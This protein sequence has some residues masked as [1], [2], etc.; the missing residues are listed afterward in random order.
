M[1]VFLDFEDFSHFYLF[2]VKFL[3]QLLNL[4]N[5]G[6]LWIESVKIILK[7]ISF[8]H[9]TSNTS[10]WFSTD[11]AFFMV[12]MTTLEMDGLFSVI[13]RIPTSLTIPICSETIKFLIIIILKLFSQPLLHEI[14]RDVHDID[15]MG[16]I[17]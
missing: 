6:E 8:T 16:K 7:L 10:H 11:N 15:H 17:F 13:D 1:F 9:E 5:F 12:G 4:F 2:L 14:S 3:E